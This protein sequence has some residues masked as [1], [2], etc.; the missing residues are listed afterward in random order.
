LG[1]K[2]F[3][4]GTCQSERGPDNLKTFGLPSGKKKKKKKRSTV[5][6]EDAVIWAAVGLIPEIRGKKGGGAPKKKRGTN[7]TVAR[8]PG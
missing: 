3:F 6:S 5:L 2:R 4:E 7:G 1:G 8:W